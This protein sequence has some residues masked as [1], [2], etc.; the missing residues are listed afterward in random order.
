[1]VPIWKSGS[2]SAVREVR[3]K[4]E[5]LEGTEDS[6][7]R[8]ECQ[9][10]PLGGSQKDLHGNG[11]RKDASELLPAEIMHEKMQV[12]TQVAW[13]AFGMKIRIF[14]RYTWLGMVSVML[15]QEVRP[16][17]ARIEKD[18]DSP[19]PFI[20]AGPAGRHDSMHGIMSRDEKPGI[21]ES[22]N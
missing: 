8:P 12:P 1:M 2:T 13:A 10:I 19:D 17:K 14:T 7:Q 9:R 15:T 11:D 21:E 5:K 20:E 6:R 18:T 16:F 22:Q 4:S 3:A